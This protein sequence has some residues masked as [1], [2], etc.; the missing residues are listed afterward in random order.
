[1]CFLC[2]K[3]SIKPKDCEMGMLFGPIVHAKVLLEVSDEY[4]GN[5]GHIRE[6]MIAAFAKCMD[7]KKARESQKRALQSYQSDEKSEI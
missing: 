4:F 7:E 1:M 5:V 2:G 3:P 6:L